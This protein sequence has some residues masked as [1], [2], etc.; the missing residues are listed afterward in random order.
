MIEI[1]NIKGQ[2]AILL[3]HIDAAARRSAASETQERAI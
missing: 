1:E 3:S 2:F